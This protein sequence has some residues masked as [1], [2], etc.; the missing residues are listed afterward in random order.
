MDA[1]R[2]LV[3]AGEPRVVD[4]GLVGPFAQGL[5]VISQVV[6][7]DG[8]RTLASATVT[9]RFVE[10]AAGTPSPCVERVEGA[11]RVRV[12][13]RS[14]SVAGATISPGVLEL[15]GLLP[16]AVDG[17]R[18]AGGAD[19]GALD[20]G[21]ALTLVPDDAGLSS[22]SVPQRLFFGG[23][24]V[25]VRSSGAGVPAFTSPVLETPAQLTLS[26]PRCMPTCAPVPRDVPLRVAWANVS[27][28]DVLVQLSTPQVSV[29][30][31]APAEQAVLEVPAAL[32]AE[33]TPTVG[34]GDATLLVL[35]RRAVR[36]D[37]G[38]FDV[39]LSAETPTL[40]PIEV[41]P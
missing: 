8:P 28:A 15:E 19:A 4:G 5:I 3:D 40:L 37:A 13:N 39:T 12:C 21:S 29:T 10:V 31:Q 23:A 41:L 7:E 6:R 32:L 17:G 11:C 26:V 1:G 20:A 22:L 16:V 36:F 34:P 9:A 14:G 2:P 30:C 25:T 18:D 33:L 27:G 38:A 24:Q 35:A